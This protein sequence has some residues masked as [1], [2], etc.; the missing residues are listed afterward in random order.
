[1]AFGFGSRALHS[2]VRCPRRL[3]FQLSGFRIIYGISAS[4][5]PPL[6]QMVLILRTGRCTQERC[7]TCLAISGSE[8]YIDWTAAAGL[9]P[10]FPF[11]Q[12]EVLPEEAEALMRNPRCEHYC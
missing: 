9:G 2:K 4:L 8:A 1:M 7:W 5:C 10:A 12:K 3:L 11:F 6:P